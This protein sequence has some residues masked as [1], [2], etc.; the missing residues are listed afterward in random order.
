MKN[1]STNEIR[2]EFLSYFESN[3]HLITEGASVIPDDDPTLLFINSGMAPM[4]RYFTRSNT[5]EHE[6]SKLTVMYTY[7][8][9]R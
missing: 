1:L 2:G 5:S 7:Y 4:K 8:R 9:Y 3:G 6:N